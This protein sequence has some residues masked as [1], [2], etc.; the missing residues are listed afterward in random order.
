MRFIDKFYG[1]F[2]WILTGFLF[3][4]AFACMV[5]SGTGSLEKFYGGGEVYDV[6]RNFL[7]QNWNTDML[8]DEMEMAWKVEKDY[9]I[10]HTEVSLGKWEYVYMSLARVNQESFDATI[11]CYDMNSNVVYSEPVNLKEGHNLLTIPGAEYNR[12]DICVENQAGLTFDIEKLQFR[13][14]PPFFS[15]KPFVG[16][17]FA[18]FAAFMFVTG[19]LYGIFKKRIHKISWYVWI[20]RLQSIF[21]Y[22]GNSGEI[23]AEKYSKQSRSR[24]RTILFT[25]L[26]LGMQVAYILRWNKKYFQY[27]A[28]FFIIIMLLIALLCWE[29][30]LKHL[31]WKNG[32]VLSWSVVWILSIISDFILKKRYGCLGY[33]MLFGMGFVFFMW[34]NMKHREELLLN[35]FRGIEWNFLIIT[36][37]CY[38]FRPWLPG[39]RYSG[40]NTGPNGFAMYIL[41]VLMAILAQMQFSVKNKSLLKNDIL[42]VVALGMCV[43]FMWKTQSVTSLMLAVLVALIYSF[44]AWINRKNIGIL[45]IVLYL[46]LFVVGFSV[47]DFGVYHVSRALNLEI[48]YDN[49]FYVD[50]VTDHPFMINVKAAEP[51][52]DNRILYKL[53]TSTSLDELT[54]GRTKYWK[55]YLRDMNLWGHKNNPYFY[56]K[57]QAAHNGILAMMH[58]YGIF[59]AVPY[60]LM[61]IYNVYFACGYF[62]R[63][64]KEKKYAFFVFTSMLVTGGILMV[65]NLETPFVLLSWYGLYFV[66]G[67][68]F[69]GEKTIETN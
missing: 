13:K 10:K 66:M 21:V 68:Y 27:V 34:G 58:R 55:A 18:F 20:D 41:F 46:G 5:I 36:L 48:K 69:D 59:T 56:G 60:V 52:N 43:C 1:K 39:Y 61:L 62:I 54:T 65:E 15:M 2:V 47:N 4:F 3:A 44:K 37:Y 38:L 63:H 57:R 11:V 50:T 35:F 9:A 67:V 12:M 30:P 53:R 31:N 33:C 23:L 45:G 51:G 49:D 29:K 32:L 19:L 26:I 24:F 6:R 16:M 14:T 28:L 42:R 22:V 25:I 17:F 7:K 40:Y 64:W 8:Y